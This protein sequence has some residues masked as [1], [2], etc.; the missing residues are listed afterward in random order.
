MFTIRDE[1][2]Q[3]FKASTLEDFEDRAVLFLR[4]DFPGG[5]ARF[6][7]D[8]LRIRV[9]ESIPRAEIFGLE[10]EYA[11][12]CFVQ[13]LLLLGDDFET[14][15]KWE[16]I[17]EGLQDESVDANDRATLALTFALATQPAKG[18]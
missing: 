14:N 9:R 7:D 17:V 5:A 13:L 3:A 11:V 10:S 12:M 8:E 4:E 16:V 6:R 2:L 18:T 15:P 1:Q